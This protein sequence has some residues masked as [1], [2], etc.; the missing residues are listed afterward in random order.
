MSITEHGI[1]NGAR[2]TGETL[3][4]VIDDVVTHGG[5]KAKKAFSQ[6]KDTFDHVIDAAGDGADKAKTYIT[7]QMHE[8]P[9][10]TAATALGAGVLLGLLLARR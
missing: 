4:G 9:V 10:A 5:A 7:R 2:K 1:A 3:K 8:R 6:S